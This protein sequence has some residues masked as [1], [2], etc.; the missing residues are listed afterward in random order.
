MRVVGATA[1]ATVA[2]IVNA[3]PSFAWTQEFNAFDTGGT[4]Y[5]GSSSY[6]CAFWQEPNYTSTS[7][8][9]YIDSSV[10]SDNYDFGTAL[11]G[12]FSNFNSAP[13]YEPYIYSCY[14]DGCGPVSYY[15]S[16]LG[17]GIYGETTFPSLGPVEYGSKWGY[18]RFFKYDVVYFNTSPQAHWNNTLTWSFNSQ[19]CVFQ[20]D[21]RKVATHETGH[22]MSLGHTS[23][24]AVMHQGP[25]NFYKL[26][27]N[28]IQGLQAIYNGT[29]PSS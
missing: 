18:Y 10:D 13:A 20:A 19:T 29:S 11:N 7:F 23:Y 6:P 16:S 2:L 14:R 15:G 1:L 17:C 12:A 8:N 3:L 21:G 9:G 4:P 5:C 28:D 27:S 22:V 24:T 26:Q 25:E